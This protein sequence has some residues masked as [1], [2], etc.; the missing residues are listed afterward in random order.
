M[1]GTYANMLIFQKA[2]YIKP[3]R[4]GNITLNEM[5]CIKEYFHVA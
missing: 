5:L 1:F 4:Q 2:V 3:R